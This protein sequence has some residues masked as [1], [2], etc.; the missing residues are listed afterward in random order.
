MPVARVGTRDARL[1]FRDMPNR[2]P[3]RTPKER[4]HRVRKLI[5]DAFENYRGSAGETS[6]RRMQLQST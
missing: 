6:V 2:G 1:G 3:M 4:V 5:A